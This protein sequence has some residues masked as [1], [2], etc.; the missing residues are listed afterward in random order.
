M[1]DV[2]VN[3]QV[4]DVAPA[5]DAIDVVAEAS[6]GAVTVVL[7]GPVGPAG[8][9]GAGGGGFNMTDV[10]DEIDTRIATHNQA[11]ARHPG[12][13]SGRDFVALFQNGLI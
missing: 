2:F 5:P 8:A 6:P 4:I 10:E 3:T 9:D 11:T 13:T 12:S 1:S 7:G